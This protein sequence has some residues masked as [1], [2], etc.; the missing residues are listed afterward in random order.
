[1]NRKLAASL[2]LAVIG[3]LVVGAI[4][5]NRRHHSAGVMLTLHVAVS[6]AEQTE[7]VAGLAKS[8]RFKYFMGKDA[9]VK[10][11]LAQKLSIKSVPGSSL[12]E[13]QIDVPTREEGRR[14]AEGFISTLQVLCGNQARVTLADQ[15]IR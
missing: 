5:W 14:Y 6:P 3:V 10:P 15:T 4:V 12:V 13:A 7:F 11:V 1:M 2:T 8:A 9:G